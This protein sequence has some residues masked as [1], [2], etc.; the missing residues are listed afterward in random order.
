MPCVFLTLQVGANG[1]GSRE[2]VGTSP[3][4]GRPSMQDV[5]A[6]M[7]LKTSDASQRNAAPG[8]L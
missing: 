4:L 6:L 7:F 8:I 1:F 3:T 5:S 2:G